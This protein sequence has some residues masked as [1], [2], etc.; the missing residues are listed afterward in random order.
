MI[1]KGIVVDNTSNKIR[2]TFPDISDSISYLLGVA[3]HVGVLD[4][5]SNVI[6]AFF[7][8]SFNDGVIIG[9]VI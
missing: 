6:V 7:T 5:G 8:D 2:V 9:K 1:K 4:I 3:S